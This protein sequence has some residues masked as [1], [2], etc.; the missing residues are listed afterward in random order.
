[1]RWSWIAIWA[2]AGAGCDPAAG[3]AFE[4]APLAVSR[5]PV[6]DQ[7]GTRWDERPG[8]PRIGSFWRTLANGIWTEHRSRA[9]ALG[10]STYHWLVFDAPD[11]LGSPLVGQLRVYLDVDGDARFG[12]GDEM[13]GG[14]STEGFLFAANPVDAADS[15]TGQAIPPGVHVLPFP[16]ACDR[17]APAVDDT[18]CA[19][20]IGAPCDRDADC[21]EGVCLLRAPRIW[22]ERICAMPGETGGCRPTDARWVAT[23]EGDLWLPACREGGCA[24]GQICVAPLGACLPD[25]SQSL[26]LS[27][28]YTPPAPCE[29]H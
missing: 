5:G 12:E 8:S 21:G 29:D 11:Q 25:Q 6:M 2:L 4:G 23:A 18:P 17:T 14:L 15:P 3:G 10:E 1:M 22:T 16:L 9:F 28:R 19:V 7:S 26:V 20:T 13:I 24:A 27:P